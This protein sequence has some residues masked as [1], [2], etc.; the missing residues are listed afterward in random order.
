MGGEDRGRTDRGSCPPEHRP[1]F[2]GPHG[3]EVRVLKHTR[4]LLASTAEGAKGAC[5]LKEG[6]AVCRAAIRSVS[7]Y[8]RGE[9]R[10][11]STPV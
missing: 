8:P 1:V 2:R 10:F 9:E 6:R 4:T 11:R 5:N 3:V 7:A